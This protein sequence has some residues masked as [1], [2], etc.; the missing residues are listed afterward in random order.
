M[1]LKL[2]TRKPDA[3]WLKL[4]RQRGFTIATGNSAFRPLKE[5][6]L[7]I[8]GW[9]VCVPAVE[10][11]LH[12]LL[13]RGQRFPGRSRSLKGVPCGCHANTAALYEQLEDGKIVTGYALSRDGSGDSTVGC[14]STVMSSSHVIETT[15]KRI[16]YF[17]VILNE[18]EADRFVL[19]NSFF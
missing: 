15:V 1:P 7:T 4:A 19:A 13:T 8:G 6:L 5:K 2:K 11:G 14:G 3:Q 10:E 17:G 16:S 9:S 18:V 12:A